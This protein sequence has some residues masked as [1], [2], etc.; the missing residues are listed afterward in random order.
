MSRRTA[1]VLVF[2]LALVTAGCRSP[3][4]NFSEAP[5]PINQPMSF[6]RKLH[7]AD[8]WWAVASIMSSA[9]ADA[10]RA[11]P[12]L[13]KMPVYIEPFG[14]DVPFNASLRELLMTRLH[15]KGVVISTMP[16][17]ALIVNVETRLIQAQ[18]DRDFTPPCLRANECEGGR[19]WPSGD[20]EI[21]WSG[22]PRGELLVTSS[23]RLNGRFVFRRSDLYYV[24]DGD[25]AWYLTGMT[26]KPP[27]NRLIDV[28][29]EYEDRRQADWP[30]QPAG[31]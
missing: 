8:H 20:D 31:Y 11:S 23:I 27:P 21:A 24:G 10:L 14:D 18:R 3:S 7:S 26:R 12:D 22:V 29:R 19:A 30:T 28:V 2:A 25:A 1:V 17:D 6:Q 15:E 16:Y 4:A 9:L 5:V 13:V